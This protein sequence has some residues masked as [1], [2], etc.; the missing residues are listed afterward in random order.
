MLCRL[1]SSSSQ[2]N[3]DLVL[4]IVQFALNST[5]HAASGHR[6]LYVDFSRE[7]ELPLEAA[8]CDVVDGPVQSVV[9]CIA[10][11]Q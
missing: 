11:M 10:A 8:V 5:C 2:A 7:S 6:F 4:S 9:D 3:W 1:S